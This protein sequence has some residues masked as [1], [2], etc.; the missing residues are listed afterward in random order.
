MMQQRIRFSAR[1]ALSK[2]RIQTSFIDGRLSDFTSSDFTPRVVVDSFPFD[3]YED[4]RAEFL[5]RWRN[6]RGKEME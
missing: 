6:I 5:R 3:P 4:H 1:R 2:D